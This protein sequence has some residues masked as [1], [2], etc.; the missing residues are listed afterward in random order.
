MSYME[1]HPNIEL[2]QEVSNQELKIDQCVQI[3][4]RKW[5]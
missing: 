4:I 5:L 1:V 3:P 2:P